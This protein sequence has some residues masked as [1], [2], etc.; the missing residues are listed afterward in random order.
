M[1]NNFRKKAPILIFNFLKKRNL[2]QHVLV[3]VY[4]VEKVHNFQ[5]TYINSE[6]RRC[7][8]WTIEKET[9]MIHSQTVN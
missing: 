6:H 2:W 8:N 1:G 3:S 5:R 4:G 9:H 7:I